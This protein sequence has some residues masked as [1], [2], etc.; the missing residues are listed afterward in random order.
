MAIELSN[1]HT[2]N[3]YLLDLIYNNITKLTKIERA[4]IHKIISLTKMEGKLNFLTATKIVE[5]FSNSMKE[6]PIFIHSVL[7]KAE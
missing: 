2:V 7:S 5:Q 4:T 1:N 6:M 3:K